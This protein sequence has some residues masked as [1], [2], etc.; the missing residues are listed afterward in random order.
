M[1]IAMA[2]PTR[3]PVTS[4]L[5]D[6]ALARDNAVSAP[7]AREKEKVTTT[8]VSLTPSWLELLNDIA[9]KRKKRNGGRASMSAVIMQIL[10]QHRAELEAERDS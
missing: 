9:Q 5:E 3:S 1:L 2:K 8:G 7:I 4:A 6:A 10:E